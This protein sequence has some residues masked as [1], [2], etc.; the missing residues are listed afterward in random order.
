ML[1]S[2]HELDFAKSLYKPYKGAKLNELNVNSIYDIGLNL[3]LPPDGVAHGVSTRTDQVIIWT[4]KN[5]N[6]I[7]GLQAPPS[8]NVNIM[9]ELIINKLYENGKIDDP[10]KSRFTEDIYDTE[11]PLMQHALLRIIYA[12]TKQGL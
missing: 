12:F 10:L 9:H 1:D 6:R 2:F 3:I 4:L 7:M 8:F 5:S 11:R